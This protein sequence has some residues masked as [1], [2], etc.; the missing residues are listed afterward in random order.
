MLA[1]MAIATLAILALLSAMSAADNQPPVAAISSPRTGAEYIVGQVVV[2]DGR[3]SWDDDLPNL[4]YS[5]NFTDSVVEGKDKAVVQRSFLSPRDYLVVLTVID[6]QSWSSI[7]SVRIVVRAQNAAPVAAIASPVEGGR[8]LFDRP[9]QFDGSP[10]RDPEGGTLRYLWETNRTG[11]LIGDR[12][13]FSIKLPLG[14]YRVTLSV[15]DLAGLGTSATINISVESNRPPE[16][17]AGAVAPAV[18]PEE[19]EGGFEFRITYMDPDNDP[20]IEVLLKVGRR[21]VFTAYAMAKAAGAGSAYR[22]GVEYVA[23]GPLTVGAHQY[24][25]TCRDEF[26]GCATALA[27]GPQV[28]LVEELDIQTLGAR[29][30]VNWS[31]LGSTTV[32]RASSPAPPPTGAVVIS[33]VVRFELGIGEWS[34]ARVGLSYSP[35]SAIDPTSIG[36]LR[37]DV[38]RG[39]WVPAPDM[40][41]NS[42]AHR[43]EGAF[44]GTAG[45]YAVMGSVSEDN[46]NRPPDLRI[47]YDAKDA[48]AGREVGFDASPSTDPDGGVLLFSWSFAPS[49][50]APA[51][52]EWTAGLRIEHL[53]EDPGVYEVLLKAIDGGNEHVLSSNVSVRRYQGEAPGPLD[54]PQVLFVMGLL[55]LLAVVLAVSNRIRLGRPK[56]YEAHFGRAYT[57]RRE[58]DEYSQLFRKLTED[59][60]RGRPPGE[61][62]TATVGEGEGEDGDAAVADPDEDE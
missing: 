50:G 49:P 41:H 56:G 20:P 59:E 14:R 44:V 18:G 33:S 45:V 34:E 15:Y 37:Y 24:V 11:D 42:T 19:L 3:S 54:N 6:A 48:Y 1:L 39:L 53:F 60:L 30:E 10:S 5:W 58:E 40:S 55:L 4:T 26:Y 29:L 22:N 51:G 47:A 38:G 17:V 13:R 27:N 61:G 35:N 16:L 28:Y 31:E 2:F 43:V 7:A 12:E 21:G 46:Q 62:G 36:L 23:H 8:F 32:L 52:T 25:F 57:D 9:I